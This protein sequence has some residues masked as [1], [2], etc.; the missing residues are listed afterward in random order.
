MN[1]PK[2]SELE[3]LT[4]AIKNVLTD[5]KMEVLQPLIEKIITCIENEGFDLRDFIN[6]LVIYT[7]LKNK[8]SVSFYLEKAAMELC[9][10]DNA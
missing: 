5:G 10:Q 8:S 6:G 7:D 1:T 9:K 4:S 2:F 3:S